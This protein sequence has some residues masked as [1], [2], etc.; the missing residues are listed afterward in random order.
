MKTIGP[1]IL[2]ILFVLGCSPSFE[3]K[4]LFLESDNDAWFQ[5]GTANWNWNDGIITGTS[6]S[7]SSFLMTTESY[8]FFELSLE[9][10]PDSTVNSGIFIR[11]SNKEVSATDC[12]E[13]NIWD[14]HPN[15]DFRTGALVG[16]A[17]PLALVETLN[18]W[19]T[20]RIKA[21]NGMLQAW[22]NDVLTVDYRDSDLSEGYIAIQAGE[23][24][25]IQFRNIKVKYPSN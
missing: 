7:G 11:C 8:S 15:Q 17:T 13:F 21:H 19:N 16:R 23:T 6:T 22:I 14:L 2:L 9:F 24:G 5:D 25:S 18:Q 20:Y 10:N 1:L 12:Y 3:E 4:T